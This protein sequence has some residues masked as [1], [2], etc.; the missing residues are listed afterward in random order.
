ML[1]IRNVVENLKYDWQNRE[2]NL[3]VE[4]WIGVLCGTMLLI[5]QIRR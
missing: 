1:I 3:S 4:E 2:D 5:D